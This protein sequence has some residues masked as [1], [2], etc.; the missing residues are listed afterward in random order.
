MRDEFDARTLVKRY[1]AMLAEDTRY[2]FDLE[3]FEKIIDY[4]KDLQRYAEALNAT[5]LAL[6]QYPFAT[7]L[8]FERAQML[9]YSN[10]LAKGMQAIAEIED[11]Y[12]YPAQLSVLRATLYA[13][14]GDYH[15]A[16][17]ALQEALPDAPDPAEIHYR[18]GYA[19]QQLRQYREASK[20]YKK[21][22]RI[23]P[24][25]THA[26][27]ELNECL[28]VIGELDEA[29]LFYTSFTDKDPFS[30]FAWYNLGLLHCKTDSNEDALQAFEYATLS[31]KDFDLAYKEAGHVYMNLGQYAQAQQQYYFA[32]EYGE[33][34]PHLLCCLG[35]SFER[36]RDYEGAIVNYK[37]AVRLDKDCQDAYFGIA[38]CLFA[39]TRWHEAISYLRKA[40]NL[41]A[42][43]EQYW[44]ILGDTEYQL[45][46]VIGAL[47]A[48]EKSAAIFGQNPRLWLNWSWVY[49]EQG[50]TEQAHQIIEQGIEECAQNALLYYRATAYYICTG[51][52]NEGVDKLEK[53]LSLNYEEHVVL[54]DFFPDLE[55][56]KTIYHII[57]QIKNNE[58]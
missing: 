58:S 24:E 53:A 17:I 37:E 28:D 39:Q 51:K 40:I 43:N 14:Y 7:E 15:N 23:D 34:D 26:V 11:A 47:E 33:D 38:C 13:R 19:H 16:L 22:L 35:A 41:D 27:H 56:Q 12:P 42:E 32:L 31:Q 29:L 55:A 57:Q 10:Q 54:Y 18:I 52:Y 50:D 5:E 3:A 9:I 46:N 2:F 30:P 45:G 1:E 44:V 36:M 49:F 48:Y 4:Y 25:L 21:A 6:E 8:Q 20:H